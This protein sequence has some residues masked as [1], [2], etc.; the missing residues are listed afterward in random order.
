MERTLGSPQHPPKQPPDQKGFKKKTSEH[1]EADD[2]EIE[3]S[4]AAHSVV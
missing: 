4:K 2:T 1:L 3:T